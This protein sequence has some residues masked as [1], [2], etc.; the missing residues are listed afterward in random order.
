MTITLTQVST[1]LSLPACALEGNL[2][3]GTVVTDN[4]VVANQ[5][6]T[7]DGATGGSD[8]LEPRTTKHV[9]RIQ[10][11]AGAFAGISGSAAQGS[12]K[13]ETLKGATAN[14]VPPRSRPV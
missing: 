11:I 10:P 7:P 8:Y 1:R 13:P 14:G 5:T 4:L 3:V 6:W 2:A 9:V 12:Q